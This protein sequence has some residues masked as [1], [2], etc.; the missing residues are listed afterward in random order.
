MKNKI[1]IGVVGCGE[2]SINFIRLFLKHPYV[3]SVCVAD[4]VPE[5]AKSFGEMFN[6]SY[7]DSFEKM[8]EADINAVAIFTPRHTHG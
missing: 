2:F 6:V 7:Y 8:L 5:K 1:K 4:N 3:E